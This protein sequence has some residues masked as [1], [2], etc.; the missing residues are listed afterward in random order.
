M[1]GLINNGMDRHFVSQFT[2]KHKKVSDD[3][4]IDGGLFKKNIENKILCILSPEDTIC[5]ISSG[6]MAEKNKK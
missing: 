3:R 6:S 5:M 4:A 1:T 2:A